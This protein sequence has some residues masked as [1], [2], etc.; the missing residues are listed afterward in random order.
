MNLPASVQVRRDVGPRPQGAAPLRNKPQF[1]ALP[2]SGFFEPTGC[3]VIVVIAFRMEKIPKRDFV[4]FRSVDPE[5]RRPREIDPLD[6][7]PA[8]QRDVSARGGFVV[9]LHVL[10]V[11]IRQLALRIPQLLVLDFQLRLV[12]RQFVQK[13][14]NIH[15]NRVVH[16]RAFRE[17]GLGF[18][19]Q[20]QERIDFFIGSVRHRR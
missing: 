10:P 1:D 18:F 7:P 13:L 14:Q 16:F 5:K 15:G 20:P 8:V 17:Q 6:K 19:P 3:P 2:F 9:Q 12:D 11:K 4:H